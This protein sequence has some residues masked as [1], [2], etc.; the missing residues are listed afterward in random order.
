MLWELETLIG[1]DFRVDLKRNQKYSLQTMDT[2]HNFDAT[3]YSDEAPCQVVDQRI[4]RRVQKKIGKTLF[5]KGL[6]KV[7]SLALAGRMEEEVL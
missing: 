1:L 4:S 5:F 7:I 3:T 2:F 6:S